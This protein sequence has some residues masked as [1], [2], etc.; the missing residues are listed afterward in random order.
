MS[1]EDVSGVEWMEDG[2]TVVEHGTWVIGDD[3][4]VE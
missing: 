2:L 3:K 4:M 1:R